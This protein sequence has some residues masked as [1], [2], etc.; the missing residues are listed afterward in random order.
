MI[1]ALTFASCAMP[2]AC[3]PWRGACAWNHARYLREERNER[4]SDRPGVG[5]GG[6][7]GAFEETA[8][9]VGEEGGVLPMAAAAAG[10]L[11]SSPA[12][13]VWLRRR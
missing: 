6:G 2:S 12:A 3:R 11:S 5:G 7:A 4:V 10:L 13:A 9:A 8:V 1:G